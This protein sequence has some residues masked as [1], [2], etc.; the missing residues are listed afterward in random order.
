MLHVVNLE[1]KRLNLEYPNIVIN[2]FYTDS[3]ND[4]PLITISKHSFIVKHDNITPYTND[5]SISPKKEML[6]YL[7][8]GFLTMLI[9][10]IVYYIWTKILFKVNNQINIQLANVISWVCAVTFAYFANRKYVFQI[11]SRFDIT[12]MCNFFLSRLLTLG[13]DMLLMFILT[14]FTLIN[15]LWIKVFVQV[16][17]V[18]LN[19]VISKFVVFNNSKKVI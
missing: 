13:I 5:Y 14:T 19:Y 11:K 6:N 3:L 10:I 16:I 7:I 4:L 17:V 2:N 9:T 12:E 15:D 1:V 18:I 8:V